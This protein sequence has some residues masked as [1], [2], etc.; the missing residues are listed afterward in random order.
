MNLNWSYRPETLKSEILL[1]FFGPCCLEFWRITSI[2]KR[3]LLPCSSKLCASILSHPWFKFEL[4]PE[5]AQ[6]VISSA[7][8]TSQFDRW[9]KNYRA[10]LLCHFKFCASFHSHLWIQIGVTVRKCPNWAKVCFDFCD[11]DLWSLTL[12]LRM[13]ITS[14]NG[15]YS[16]KFHDDTM[17]GTLWKRCSWQTNGYRDRQTDRQTGGRGRSAWSM[18]KR[19]QNVRRAVSTHPGLVM[20][21]SVDKIGYHCCFFYVHAVPNHYLNHVIINDAPWYNI[22]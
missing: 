7:R 14:V 10:L 9:P 1:W 4:P 18:P 19:A 8:V 5:N 2:N 13:A 3:E 11:L 6:I 20:H 22:Q 17:L 21:I 15:N 16:W 12:T